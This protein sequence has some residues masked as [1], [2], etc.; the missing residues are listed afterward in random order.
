MKPSANGSNRYV[1]TMCRFSDAEL[2]CVRT[3]IF[4]R[5]ELRQLLIGTSIRRYF[6]PSGTAGF[7]RSF[8]RGNNRLPAP[9]ARTI[10]STCVGFS[11]LFRTIFF[12]MIHYAETCLLRYERSS[13]PT[14]R[15]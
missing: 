5:P 14:L 8:V 6:P 2:N 9:P 13:A 7:D 12:F 11:L 10:D 4:L 15:S 3:K 1:M